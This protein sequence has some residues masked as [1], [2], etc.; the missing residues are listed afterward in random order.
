MICWDAGAAT[1]D[2]ALFG[3]GLP[4]R[5]ATSHDLQDASDRAWPMQTNSDARRRYRRSGR[6][7]SCLPESSGRATGRSAMRNP[8]VDASH[9]VR[10]LLIGR[11]LNGRGVRHLQS[12]P[13]WSDRHVASRSRRR[14]AVS[15]FIMSAG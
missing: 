10:D 4:R 12:P 5:R 14:S 11:T 7:P 8:M 9:L 3:S 1:L 6:A 13:R 15:A 2:M